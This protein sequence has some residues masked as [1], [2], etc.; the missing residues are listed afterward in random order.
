MAAPRVIDVD[1]ARQEG[2]VLYK[3]GGRLW[4]APEPD[5]DTLRDIV[6]L[7]VQAMVNA[8]NELQKSRTAIEQDIRDAEPGA[9][10]E[11][12]Q[13]TLAGIDALIPQLQRL[14]F[15]AN[16]EGQYLKAAYTKPDPDQPRD[17]QHPGGVLDVG[18]VCS[19]EE[20]QPIPEPWARAHLSGK[21][22]GTILAE[23]LGEE[24]GRV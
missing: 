5:M 19:P 17:P 24:L 12:G 20:R 8:A 15:L 14:L 2:A 7:D 10:E 13:G 11:A 16:E 4:L 9:L 21:R 6:L 3:I 23:V 18:E 22:A 1:Q